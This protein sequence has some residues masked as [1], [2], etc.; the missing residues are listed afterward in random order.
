MDGLHIRYLRGGDNGRDIEIGA[1]TGRRTDADG[2]VRLAQIEGIGIRLRVD[3]HGLD[4]E[5]AAGADHPL[6]DLAP[7]GHQDTAEHQRFLIRKRGCPNSTGSL[8]STSSSTISPTL[9]ALISFMTFM[10]SMMHSTVSSP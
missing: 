6:G 7:V 4:T 3:G 10:A 8:L 2:L 1:G 9:S 5:L